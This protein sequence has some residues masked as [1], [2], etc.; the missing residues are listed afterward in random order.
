MDGLAVLFPFYQNDGIPLHVHH[1][2]KTL[3]SISNGHAHLFSHQEK[4][5][6]CP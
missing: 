5:E 3:L 6:K 2:A 4:V 1:E